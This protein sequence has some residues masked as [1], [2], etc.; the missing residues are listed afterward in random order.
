M[1]TYNERCITNK[2]IFLSSL[3]ETESEEADAAESMLTLTRYN[4]ENR[5]VLV[6]GDRK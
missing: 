6:V 5:S 3:F 1:I 4:C 2:L